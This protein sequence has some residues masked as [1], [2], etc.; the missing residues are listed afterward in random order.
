MCISQ[1][2]TTHITH[3]IHSVCMYQNSLFMYV[4]IILFA[5]FAIIKLKIKSLTNGIDF[6]SF[7]MKIQMEQKPS[8]L[9][10]KK[11]YA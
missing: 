1:F 9:L 11:N 3:G 8:V 6:C 7:V 10:L 4:Y 2:L 5:H